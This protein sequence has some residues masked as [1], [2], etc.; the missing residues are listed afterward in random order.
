MGLT[1]AATA[2]VAGLVLSVPILGSVLSP[3]VKQP[4]NAW[5]IVRLAAP[6]G[7]LREV[8]RADTIP[9]GHTQKV[10]YPGADP[11]PWA[12]ATGN[13]ASWL[14][15]TGPEAF[16]AFS[17]NCT[18]LGCPVEFVQDAQLF[19]CPCHGSVFDS[20]GSVAGGPAARPLTRYP[21]RVKHGRVQILTQP[22][23]LNF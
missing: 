15:R 3:V 4:K 17:I 6:D 14:R 10:V 5:R 23:P 8:V 20:N 9:L 7:T 18:H 22:L 1:M 2:A 12:G 13:D 11:L 16:I 21:V 19:L